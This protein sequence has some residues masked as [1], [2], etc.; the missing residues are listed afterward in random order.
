[1]SLDQSRWAEQVVEQTAEIHTLPV[2]R[3]TEVIDKSQEKLKLLKDDM[4]IISN[5]KFLDEVTFENRLKY[6]TEWNVDSNG[7]IANQ[8]IEFNFSFNS[9]LPN[10]D[11][12]LRTTAWQVLPT[13][14]KYVTTAD[15]KQYSRTSLNG[16]LFTDDGKRLIIHDKT[17]ITIWELRN[18]ADYDKITHDNNEKLKN[19][20]VTDE[21]RKLLT[22][23]IEKWIDPELVLKFFTAFFGTTSLSDIDANRQQDFFTQVDREI[24]YMNMSEKRA[25]KNNLTEENKQELIDRMGNQTAM[26]SL[27][28]NYHEYPELSSL[29]NRLWIKNPE[30]LYAFWSVESTCWAN[31]NERYEAHLN[32]SS[33]WMFQ[34]LKTNL[35][36][37]PDLVDKL[38]K[39]PTDKSLNYQALE[40]Y[41]LDNPSLITAINNYDINLVSSIY[42]W[43]QY[44]KGWYHIK[45]QK[46]LNQ[47][48]LYSNSQPLGRVA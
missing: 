43:P 38:S 31:T 32:T 42:N 44:R 7:I 18:K 30:F 13:S 41:L 8:K 47:Y 22:L 36:W 39:N 24:W 16:E 48:N 37:H 12:Y 6:I 14:I 27:D 46:A 20:N 21:N 3:K 11:L 19:G 23:W 2:E 10:R 45:L 1:M 34:I 33:I 28:H 4:Q 9:E 26:E 17:Q 40:V 15:G 35:V 5:L 25:D 29:W